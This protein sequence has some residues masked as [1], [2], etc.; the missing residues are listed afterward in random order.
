MGQLNPNKHL[1]EEFVSNLQGSSKIE[2]AAL[3][4]L[5]PALVIL[6]SFAILPQKGF[7]TCLALDFTFIVLPTVLSLTVFADKVYGIALLV[8][9]LLGMSSFLP[10]LEREKLKSSSI[11]FKRP[12]LTYYRFIMI[13]VTC[14]TILA[15][16]FTAFPR[17]YAKT[18]T[19]GTGLMDLGVGSFVAANA[20]VSRQARSRDLLRTRTVDILKSVSPLL[21]LGFARLIA[22]K[23]ADYQVHVGEYGVHWNFFFTLAAVSLLTSVIR[24]PVSYCGYLGLGILSVHQFTLRCGLKD[25]ILSPHRSSG[26][27]DLNKE[28]IFSI[29]GYWSL[30]LLSVH[31]GQH[32]FFNPGGFL[33]WIASSSNENSRWLSI[34]ELWLLDG[35]LWLLVVVLDSI[36]ENVS[37]RTCNMAY[38]MFVL[39]Q[40]LEVMAIFASAE[41]FLS[42]KLVLVEAVD[43]NMLLTFLVANVLTGLVNLSMDTI[44]VLPGLSVVI[45]VGYM[46]LLVA[47]VAMFKV[48][49]IR[50][51]F[52]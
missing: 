22:T 4:A 23:G 5:I 21:A 13:L 15:V 3:S 40:N 7:W 20:I 45:V 14:V 38:V 50:A 17:R 49:K 9:I 30:Y 51:K 43:D 28:G 29:F 24:M 39:A 26:L 16:D 1:K 37:R 18:E 41:A 6:R 10:F 32:I 46:A 8:S 19:Y 44:F 27:V 48:Y 36:V 35:A 2:I 42:S 52:W 33:K 12:F 25:Y 11:P 31:L 47:I 34:A